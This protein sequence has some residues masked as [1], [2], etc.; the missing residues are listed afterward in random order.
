MVQGIFPV[1]SLG[2]AR[3]RTQEPVCEPLYIYPRSAEDR[4]QPKD[5]SPIGDPPDDNLQ[6]T[7][8]LEAD[9]LDLRRDLGILFNR[10]V[11]LRGAGR[12]LE[13][14]FHTQNF[15]SGLYMFL[16]VDPRVFNVYSASSGS[17]FPGIWLWTD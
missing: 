14:Q 1:C 2:K 12:S 15:L 6:M 16:T 13:G 8:G 3:G 5:I 17:P 11:S 7:I 4:N 10:N 9:D